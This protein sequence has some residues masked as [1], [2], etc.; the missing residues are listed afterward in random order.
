[1]SKLTVSLPGVGSTSYE[2]TEPLITIG[3]AP[4][5]LIH[6]DEPSVSSRHAQIIVS[7]ETYELIDLDST[8]GTRV[9]GQ[10]ITRVTL[11]PGDKVK[12]GKVEACFEC[13]VATENTPLPIAPQIEARPAEV[14]ARPVD[15]A[16]A[17]PFSKRVTE[18]DPMRV[19]LFAAVGVAVLAFLASM[20]ALAQMQV[21]PLP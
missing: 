16:N 10:P 6:L 3:R 11:Q 5:N 15:F 7:G 1:M 17:S 14:S 2:L 4:D 18:K 8:N 9:N 20:L 21:P 19:A 13:E 12:F